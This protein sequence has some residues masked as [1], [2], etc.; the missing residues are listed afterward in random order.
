MTIL[1]C[2][3]ILAMYEFEKRRLF[4]RND[5]D[6]DAGRGEIWKVLVL[7]FVI[8]SFMLYFS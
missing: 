7:G 1:I 8:C 3:L 2:I 6:N 4:G 5:D